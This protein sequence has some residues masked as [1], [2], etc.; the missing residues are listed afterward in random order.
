MKLTTLSI[1]LEVISDGPLKLFK[2]Q[3]YYPYVD[4]VK[5]D[6]P[7]GCNYFVGDLQLCERFTVKVLGAQAIL[8]QEQIAAAKEDIFVRFSDCYAKPY[9]TK[10][11]D[12]ELSFTAKNVSIIK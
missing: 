5:Q 1:P 12:Y 3:P 2:V 9:K 7:N 8:T 10:A 6:T 11:G 4:G